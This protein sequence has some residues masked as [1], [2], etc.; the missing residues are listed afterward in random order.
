MSYLITLSIP[1]ILIGCSLFR[2]DASSYP[3]AELPPG[4]MKIGDNFYFDQTEITNHHWCEY[5]YWTQQV[6]GESSKEYLDALPKSTAWIEL[7]SSY[8]YLDTFYL[9]HPSYRDYPAVG[10]SFQQVNNFAQWRSDRVFEYLLI[11]EEVIEFNP[12][13]NRDTFFTI[14]KY[15]T[16][17]YLDYEPDERFIHYPSY[18][19]PS[20]KDY[21]ILDA[22]QDSI[23]YKFDQ[24]CLKKD[25]QWTPIRC[26]EVR[27]QRQ[28]ETPWFEE[29][30]APV[31]QSKKG[32]Y[33]PISHLNGNVM[34]FTSKP[35]LYFG[36]S[37]LDSCN[38][39]RGLLRYDT[40]ESNAY[41]G[42][43][44]VCTFKKWGK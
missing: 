39:S 19:I 40:S 18:S 13:F 37:Y 23:N 20:M 42:F 9:R 24:Y 8:A 35:Y 32:K 28:N 34:E 2:F 41:T 29:P 26:R 7:D 3:E 17:N 12:N 44:N 4:T 5:L 15:F 36:L 21:I 10:L 6:Y 1:I 16:G 38:Q 25:N 22:L 43:R 27:I 31:I 11:R 30:T 33:R 14:E